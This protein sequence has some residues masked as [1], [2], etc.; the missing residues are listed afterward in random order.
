V[1]EPH[2]EN[3]APIPRPEGV[4][5]EDWDLVMPFVDMQRERDRLRRE[6]DQ[7]MIRLERMRLDVDDFRQWALSRPALDPGLVIA[8]D[9]RLGDILCGTYERNPIPR[10]PEVES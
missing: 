10:Q 9:H 2:A 7:A 6:L 3:E 1:P 8:L 4:P 5:Q